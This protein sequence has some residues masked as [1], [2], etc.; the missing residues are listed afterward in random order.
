MRR[1]QL[2]QPQCFSSGPSQLPNEGPAKSTA[3]KS[4]KNSA[5][6]PL[7]ELA[8]HGAGQV[9]SPG[10]AVPCQPARTPLTSN[11]VAPL[12]HGKMG[13]G[14]SQNLT[15]HQPG[16]WPSVQVWVNF[17]SAIFHPLGVRISRSV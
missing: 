9:S 5:R 17:K 12:S 16:A 2:N 15:H 14:I 10:Q 1:R 8:T 3:T 13:E 7:A 11:T 4:L 6:Q